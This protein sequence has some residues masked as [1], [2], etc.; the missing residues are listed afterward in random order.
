MA[1]SVAQMPLAPAVGGLSSWTGP[2]LANNTT[3]NVNGAG[4]PGGVAT[5]VALRQ[6]QVARQGGDLIRNM[7][8]R[9]Q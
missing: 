6:G 9:A 7:I 5:E 8:P 2:S 4:D 1:E 3:I